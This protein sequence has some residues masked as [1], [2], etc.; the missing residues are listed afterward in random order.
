MLRCERSVRE[1]VAKENDEK[2]GGGDAKKS[3]ETAMVRRMAIAAYPEQ[4]LCSGCFLRVL[5][6][7]RLSRWV[8][9]LLEVSK[10]AAKRISFETFRS[11]SPANQCYCL[12]YSIFVRVFRKG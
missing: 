2:G 6:V 1:S 9:R 7:H 5:N 12:V 11:V 3:E 4:M 8:D 10:S